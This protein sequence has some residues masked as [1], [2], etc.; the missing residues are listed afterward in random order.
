MRDN[1]SIPTQAIYDGKLVN[2]VSNGMAFIIIYD[3]NGNMLAFNS[4]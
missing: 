4:E 1:L 2:L 3:E